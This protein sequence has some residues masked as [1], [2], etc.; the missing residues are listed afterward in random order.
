M[1][2]GDGREQGPCVLEAERRGG[3]LAVGRA[4]VRCWWMCQHPGSLCSQVWVL[5]QA[6]TS[7]PGI[8]P[9]SQSLGTDASLRLLPMAARGAR[10]DGPVLVLSEDSCGGVTYISVSCGIRA[11]P[12][13]PQAWLSLPFH[14]LL[15]H[16]LHMRL[17]PKSS[18]QAPLLKEPPQDRAP[19]WEGPVA[20]GSWGAGEGTRD[21]LCPLFSC[22]CGHPLGRDGS[23]IQALEF[24]VRLE[25]GRAHQC[26]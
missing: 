19:D 20:W 8:L 10:R 15:S 2:Q 9:N 13:T 5:S 16:P 3:V 25:E 24:S 7:P 11:K 1:P 22:R 14:V 6:G 23:W 17:V 18:S 12:G 4:R 26:I 21:N